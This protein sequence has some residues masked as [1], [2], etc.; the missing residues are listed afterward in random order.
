[1]PHAL[2]VPI[3]YDL[4]V[5]TLTGSFRFA[6]LLRQINQSWSGMQ[7][8]GNKSPKM[9]FPELSQAISKKGKEDKCKLF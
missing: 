9:Q 3:L 6:D 7:V 4:V 2:C 8:C 1:M 5:N